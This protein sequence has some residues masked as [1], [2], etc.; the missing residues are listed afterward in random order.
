MSVKKQFH[1]LSN[2]VISLT[3]SIITVVF[4]SAGVWDKVT[5]KTDCETCEDLKKTVEF[6][7]NEAK[8]SVATL[9]RQKE[10][11]K[12]LQASEDSKKMKM[13]SQVFYL[14]AKVETSENMILVKEKELSEACNKCAKPVG[15][16]SAAVK[17]T[18]P[19]KKVKSH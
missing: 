11:V 14:T 15:S 6:Y 4:L 19:V 7:K 12:N 1:S 9:A 5:V 10:E 2:L 3:A 16:G 17:T 8:A 18:K 13:A